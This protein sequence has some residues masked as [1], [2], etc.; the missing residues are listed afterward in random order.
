[1]PPFAIKNGDTIYIVD[2]SQLRWFE[3]NDV[4]SDV[5]LFY[6]NGSMEV[7]RTRHAKSI[8]NDLQLQFNVLNVKDY[9]LSSN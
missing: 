5:T 8:F 6:H 4:H 9:D 2:P 1:M 3:Y 7:I